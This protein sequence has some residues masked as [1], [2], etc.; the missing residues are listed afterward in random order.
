MSSTKGSL[1]AQAA[2][3][4]EDTLREAVIL[5]T[6]ITHPSLIVQF[7]TA[8]ERIDFTGPGHDHLR[9]LIL[10]H[11]Q[12]PGIRD[13]ILDAAPAALDALLAQ[14]HVQNAPPVRNTADTD[15]AMLGL[16]EELAKLDA[17]RGARREIEDAVEDMDRLPDE[18]LTW[19]LAQ[20]A[21]ARHRADRPPRHD[22]TDL[23]EDRNALS[24]H[25]QGL[26]DAKVW[27]KKNR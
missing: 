4:V 14:P 6:L 19:R 27:E 8:L 11:A 12:S 22:A 1:L 10:T 25:L 2:G 23:G 18:G 7:Q 21:E 16:A 9:A 15:L 20:S 3:P 24:N 26:L 13:L 17:R 5:A